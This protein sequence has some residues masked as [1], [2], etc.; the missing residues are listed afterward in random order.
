MSMLTPLQTAED[1]KKI[2]KGGK[3]YCRVNQETIYAGH[4]YNIDFLPSDVYE[5]TADYPEE[6]V[7]VHFTL[8]VKTNKHN[9]PVAFMT[10]EQ[11]LDGNW[12]LILDD[13]QKGGRYE[14]AK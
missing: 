8:S 6:E 4:H 1:L 9:K 10:A 12:Y 7:P 13:I 2:K 14:V 5:V 3:L 11:L